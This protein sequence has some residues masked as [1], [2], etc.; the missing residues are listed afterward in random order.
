M[1]LS[2]S[3]QFNR[4]PSFNNR[5]LHSGLPA[6]SH[7][8]VQ[9]QTRDFQIEVCFRSTTH[10][11][12]LPQNI[13]ILRL[14]DDTSCVLDRLSS[15][16]AR[17]IGSILFDNAASPEDISC[18]IFEFANSKLQTPKWCLPGIRYKHFG[19]QVLFHETPRSNTTIHPTFIHHPLGFEESTSHVSSCTLMASRLGHSAIETICVFRYLC[20]FGRLVQ[21]G[22][23]KGKD[24][25]TYL[26]DSRVGDNSLEIVANHVLD[27]FYIHPSVGPAF[28]HTEITNY[29]SSFGYRPSRSQIT[30]SKAWRHLA[31]HDAVRVLPQSKKN[32]MGEFWQGEFPIATP[33]FETPVVF[34]SNAP[35]NGYRISNTAI[36]FAIEFQTKETPD[37]AYFSDSLATED[38][39]VQRRLSNAL[40]NIALQN[41]VRYSVQ[42]DG[43]VD[44]LIKTLAFNRPFGCPSFDVTATETSQTLAKALLL[45]LVSRAKLS[46]EIEDRQPH[47]ISKIIALVRFEGPGLVLCG[48]TL[49]NA[50]GHSVEIHA[51]ML[52]DRSV[53]EQIFGILE[54]CR[55]YPGILEFMANMAVD[56]RDLGVSY[57]DEL[58]LIER[59]SMVRSYQSWANL[60]CAVNEYCQS[61]NPGLKMTQNRVVSRN[62]IAP[63]F[64][65]KLS[66]DNG[67][68]I[69]I[70]IGTRGVETLQIV[71]LKRLSP[72]VNEGWTFE[73]K[74][75]LSEEFAERL[76]EMLMYFS[77]ILPPKTIFINHPEPVSVLPAHFYKMLEPYIARHFKS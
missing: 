43:A 2:S 76:C 50:V 31:K 59:T 41:S 61:C 66:T 19:Q 11:G 71:A 18:G 55:D 56:S 5:A 33:G 75:D 62:K 35:P 37:I 52:T 25:T 49:L 63:A 54:R 69:S 28:A 57:S 46:I 24:I 74:P 12:R 7:E 73:I 40:E 4:G 38:L 58:V 68:N 30:P 67:V 34:I 3:P 51:E 27:L 65:L 6:L 17:Q 29:L 9:I 1:N 16:V 23:R 22:L 42:A 64:I 77:E 44:K 20:P 15:G 32:E 72:V 21:I 10:S 14:A 36:G 26:L 47:Q 8:P 70:E 39:E 53:D 13:T 60:T 48:V 45:S